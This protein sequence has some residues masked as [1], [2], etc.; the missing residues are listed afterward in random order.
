MEKRRKSPEKSARPAAV[1]QKSKESEF[2]LSMAAGEKPTFGTVLE[3]ILKSLADLEELALAWPPDSFA[4]TTVLLGRSEAYRFVVSPPQGKTWPPV[5][6]WADKVEK[7]GDK[8]A[9]AVVE[10]K[11][12][13]KLVRDLWRKVRAALGTTVEDLRTWRGDASGA[14]TSWDLVCALVSLHALADMACAGVGVAGGIADDA[15]SWAR[16]FVLDANRDLVRAGA[17]NRR[18]PPHVVRVLPRLHTPQLGMTLR[19]LSMHLSAEES[20]I[21]GT[22]RVQS[23]TRTTAAKE[24]RILLLPWPLVVK[25]SAFVP[26]EHPPIEIDQAQFAFF[27][28]APTEAVSV[29]RIIGVVNRAKEISGHIDALV[30]PESAL[31]EPEF[32]AIRNALRDSGLSFVVA[33]VRGEKSNYAVID[34]LGADDP[35][36][37]VQHKH[38]RWCLEQSQIESYGLGFRLEAERRWWENIEIRPRELHFVAMHDWLTICP[39]ICEDLARVEPVSRMV[40]SVGPNLV[41]ALLEDGPQLRQRWPGRY[42]TVLAEDPGCSVLTLSSYGMVRRCIPPGETARRVVGLWK[43]AKTGVREIA[44]QSG[45]DGIVIGV[46]P[47]LTTEWT[48]DGRHDGGLTASLALFEAAQVP[49]EETP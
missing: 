9:R 46:R 40:R 42:A 1:A 15:D 39:L 28:F 18:V 32:E 22:W 43:D 25:D 12:A 7:T 48:A 27:D 16:D 19:S 20:P 6:G 45:S 14:S 44:L 41:I 36:P 30:L 10:K 3:A 8:W 2:S 24:L 17:L 31:T 49:I 21:P 4:L 34:L 11:P 26:T 47:A 29:E 38:H 37:V 23:G 35:R 5:P 13:P 33:G